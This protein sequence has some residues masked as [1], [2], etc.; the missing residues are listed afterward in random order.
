VPCCGRQCG[1]VPGSH[2][3]ERIRALLYHTHS[4]QWAYLQLFRDE[5][6]EIPEPNTFE[7]LK[8]VQRWALDYYSSLKRFMPT[9]DED[10]LNQG[11]TF[12]WAEQLMERFGEVHTAS[13]SQSIVQVVL[14][15]TYHRG[16]IATRIRELG[17]TPPLTDFIAYIWA[18]EPEPNWHVASG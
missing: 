2:A 5:P 8:A 1:R 6:V 9:V 16:Q 7:D 3:D 15:S 4:V 13:V 17:G 10:Q 11:V 14:H 18:G 12:P